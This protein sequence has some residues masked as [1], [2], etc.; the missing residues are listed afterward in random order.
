MSARAVAVEQ[1]TR[2]RVPS[3]G[4]A[5]RIGY[6]ALSCLAGWFA[7]Q[8][9]TVPTNLLIAVRNSQGDQRLFAQLLVLGGFVAWGG[10]TFLLGLAAGLFVA[11]P[12]VLVIRPCLL[13]RFRVAIY[14]VSASVAVGITLYKLHDFRDPTASSRFLRFFEALPYGI[15]SVVF[16]VTTAWVYLGLAKRRI[17]TQDAD[18]TVPRP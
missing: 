15:F 10:W 3:F 12:L 17:E 9:A 16:S 11:L 1:T 7:G 14:T 13:V 2:R 8:I 6:L 18:A 5:R 4:Y